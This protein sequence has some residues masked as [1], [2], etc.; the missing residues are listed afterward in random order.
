MVPSEPPTPKTSRPAP[1]W[2]PG[3]RDSGGDTRPESGP[4][5][6]EPI[7]IRKTPSQRIAASL[8]PE[9]SGRRAQVEGV[10][11]KVLGLAEIVG[12][13]GLVMVEIVQAIARFEVERSELL[14]NLHRMGVRSLPVVMTTAL[15]VGGIMVVQA[16][17]LVERYGAH[18]L[19]G[20]GSAFGILR[21]IGP[22]L[23]GLMISGRVGA[24]NAAELGTMQVTEQ[25]DGLRALA[26]DPGGYLLAPRFLAI[27]LT[28]VLGTIFA[29]AIALLGAAAVG[30]VLLG[31]PPAT[32]Y[33]GMTGGLL[34]AGDV[35]H[36][37]TKA[38][39]FGAVIGISSCTFGMKT[40]GGAPGVGRA[41]NSSVVVSAMGIF[42][43]DYLIS[44]ASQ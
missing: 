24:N 5:R 14:R 29:M 36:G 18:A 22:L 41:V 42:V 15:F 25:V 8:L 1:R 12:G 2:V 17:P 40:R 38:G 11:R 21:E 28:T 33:R 23:T 32:F 7:E 4:P 30:Q 20:W 13:L 6:Q 16:A 19:L 31:V 39:V 26:I 9:A 27:F 34:S 37:V 3:S 44:F 43:M 10:G 35:L